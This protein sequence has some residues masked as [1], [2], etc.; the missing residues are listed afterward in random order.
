MERMRALYSRAMPRESLKAKAARANAV[1]DRL[2]AEMP[3]ARIQLDYRT[4]MEL[5]VAVILSAQCTD[6]RVN[7]VT[8]AL[9]RRYRTVRAFAEADPGELES[10]IRTCGLFRAK[11][12]AISSAAQAILERHGGDVPTTRAELEALPGVG[13]KTAG[14]VAI[15]L[16]GDYAF[17]VDTHIRRIAHRMGFTR[18]VDPDKVELDL[19]A[20]VD[21]DKWAR[22]H[23]LLIWHGRRTCTARAPACERC[24]VAALC[25]KI[26]VRR[27]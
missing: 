17:P 8:P 3:E 23:Q 20:L 9:F 21:R 24:P 22:G 6:E 10:L 15:H 1:L 25:P 5:L 19:K 27:R 7:K 11:A 4:P 18:H 13:R 26:G 12:K 14:V 2:D 16:G